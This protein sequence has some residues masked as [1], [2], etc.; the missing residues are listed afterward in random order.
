MKLLDTNVI[1]YAA[2]KQHPYKL[3]C[4][5]ILAEAVSSDEYSV[6]A[7]LLQEIL[8][9]YQVR[10]Q[11]QLGIEIFDRVITIFPTVMPI[12]RREAI[13]ARNLIARYP[14]LVPRD[15]IHAAVVVEHRLEGIVSADRV[16]D[17]I[18]EVRRIDPLVVAA[19]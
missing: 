6:D 8:F 11:E 7:E 2:G 16:F 17:R 3:A 12:G 19:E 14:G 1:V 18:V 10:G 9:V 4:T 13:I 15:A 5:K